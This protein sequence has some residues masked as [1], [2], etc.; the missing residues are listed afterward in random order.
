MDKFD[1]K[2]RE[3]VEFPTGEIMITEYIKQ[4]SS[5]INWVNKTKAKEVKEKG[6]T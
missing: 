2:I 3:E 6:L 5:F 1:V 4:K